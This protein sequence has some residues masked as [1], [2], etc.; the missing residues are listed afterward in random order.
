MQIPLIWLYFAGGAAAGLLLASIVAFFAMDARRKAYDEE[1]T[2]LRESAEAQKTALQESLAAERAAAEA[3]EERLQRTLQEKAALQERAARVAPLEARLE[4][5]EAALAALREENVGLQTQNGELQ[6]KLAEE[7]RQFE[8]RIQEREE[9][10]RRLVAEREERL[11]KLEAW[12][13]GLEEKLE[14]KTAEN[15]ALQRQVGE[16]QTLLEEEREQTKLR[17]AE[18]KE[19]KETMQKEFKSLAAQIMEE[20]SQRFGKVSKERVEEVLKPLQQQVNEF[21]KRIEQVHTEETKEMATLLNEIKG[22]KELN[23]Q[24]GEDAVKL[25]KALRG[26]SKTQGIWGEMVLERVLEA[27]GLREGEEYEREV[28]LQDADSRR[29]RPDVIVHLPDDRDIIIDAKTSLRAYEQYVNAE[30]EEARRLYAKQ[31]LEAVKSHIERLSDKSYTQLEGVNTLDFIF[32]FMPIEGALMLALQEDPG[33]Y[34]RAF[35]R[36][37]VLVSPTTLL[38]AL[39]AVENTWRHDRQNRNALEIAKRAGELYDKF[40]GFAQDLEKVG[41]QLET[42]RKTYDGAYGKLI[43]GRGNLVRRVEELKELGARASKQMPRKIADDAELL[44]E[45][46]AGVGN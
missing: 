14:A 34:D 12:R 4:E 8:A 42:V 27:S 36:H 6:T 26:E 30:D 17:L 40:V 44:P 37:I 13:K 25:T 32:M 3:L 11:E 39:R 21:R 41:K 15:T 19:A 9:A 35:A 24:I 5:R 23:R 16:L 45:Q 10:W 31:H 33:L 28:S 18:L 38:V 20:N 2:E 43:A 22:L 1:L 46:G 29:Y 7:R